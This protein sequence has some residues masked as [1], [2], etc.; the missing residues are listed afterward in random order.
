MKTQQCAC[1][2]NK[3]MELVITKTFDVLIEE[4]GFANPSEVIEYPEPSY[5][6][7]NKDCGKEYGIDP[8]KGTLILKEPQET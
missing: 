8:S 3:F 4:D 6:C 2:N 1:G 7:Q 5:I